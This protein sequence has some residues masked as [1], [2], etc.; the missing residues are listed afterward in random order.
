MA[1]TDDEWKVGEHAAIEQLAENLWRVEAGLPRMS[2]RRVMTIA[3]RKDGALVLHSVIALD[4]ATMKQLESL[5]PLTYMIVPN[6]YHRLD[7]PRY[8]KR[9]P[10]LKVFA[11]PGSRKRVEQVVAVDGTLDELPPDDDVRFET[12][13]GIGDLERAMIVRSSDGTSIV[14]TDAVFDMD[15]RKDFMGRLICGILG[16][17]GGPRVSRI[18]RWFV[19]KD[20]KA[21]RAQLERWASLPDLQ[22]L[23]V[24]HEKVSRGADAASA[25]KIAATFLG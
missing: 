21:M 14:V 17:Q 6:G 25:L 10:Q 11:P 16:S 12:I 19:V 7:A 8:K 18:F 9:Y 23:I 15:V 2:L 20:K 5:G 22:R 3:K 1:K 4:D 24:A 13:D